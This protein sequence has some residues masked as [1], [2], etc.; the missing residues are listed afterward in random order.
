M[1]IGRRGVIKGG[2]IG[3]SVIGGGAAAMLAGPAMGT[4]PKAPNPF[5]TFLAPDRKSLTL[6]RVTAGS[7]GTTRIEE[8]TVAGVPLAR[9][10]LVQFLEN[11]ADKVAVYGAPPNH[12]VPARRVAAGTKELIYIIRGDT[13]LTAG[14]AKRKCA[15]GTL[16]LAE[17]GAGLAETA[18]PQGYMVIKVRVTA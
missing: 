1:K 13:T 5:A 12:S 10:P 2:V 15:V 9:T 7:D 18:G 16:V 14:T 8:A 17:A 4:E 6:V 3:G 11:K